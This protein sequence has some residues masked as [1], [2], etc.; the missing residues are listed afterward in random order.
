MS[1]A[2]SKLVAKVS[3]EAV[4]SK[5]EISGFISMRMHCHKWYRS[6]IQGQHLFY[7]DHVAYS[8][9]C[10]LE[11]MNGVANIKTFHQNSIK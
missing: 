3:S 2:N 8:N 11:A 5:K 6:I 10:K 7:M 4:I 1:H 9:K